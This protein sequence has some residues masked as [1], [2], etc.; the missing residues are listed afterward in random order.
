MITRNV[1]VSVFSG[2]G[3]YTRNVIGEKWQN[4]RNILKDLFSWLQEM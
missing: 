4:R 2:L 1:I 3:G